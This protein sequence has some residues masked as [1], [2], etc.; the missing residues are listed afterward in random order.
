MLAPGQPSLGRQRPPLGLPW[1]MHTPLQA[2]SAAGESSSQVSEGM[3]SAEASK[4]D[5]RAARTKRMA[6][7]CDAGLAGAVGLLLLLTC[8]VQRVQVSWELLFDP[9]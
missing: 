4:A 8:D 1:R 5:A 9:Q 3:H 2:L 6:T 7:G